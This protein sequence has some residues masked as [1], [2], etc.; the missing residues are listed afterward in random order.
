MS[1]LSAVRSG[2]WKLFVNRTS[3]RRGKTI[4]EPVTE[5]YDLHADIGEST[6]VAGQH[7]GIVEQLR[8]LAE[9][10]RKDLGDGDRAGANQRPAGFVKHAVTLTSNAEK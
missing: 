10:A 1:H 9:A 2:R 8:A 4:N 5:L 3:R 7:P 6:N